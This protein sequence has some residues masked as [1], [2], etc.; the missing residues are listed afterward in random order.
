METTIE[1]NSLHEFINKISDFESD[2]YYY[3]GEPSVNYQS[4][5]ASAFRPYHSLFSSDKKITFDSQKLLDEYY[6]EIAHELS[7]IERD[8]FL[9][10]AQHHGLPTPLIDITTSPLTALYFACSSNFEENVSKVHVFNKNGFI[11][12]SNLENKGE[13]TL[14][15]FFFDNQFTYQVMKKISELSSDF[16]Q[17]LLSSCIF[18]LKSLLSKENTFTNQQYVGKE[19][20][21]THKAILQELFQKEYSND[22]ELNERFIQL[23][24]EKFG[25]D[26]KFNNR[27]KKFRTCLFYLTEN[28][29]NNEE[30]DPLFQVHNE[31]FF[32]DEIALIIIFLINTQ[33]S[34]MVDDYLSTLKTGE[35]VFPPVIMHPSVKFDRMK[36]QEGTFLYQ[37]P[38]YR[39]T[40][41]DYIGF[42]KIENDLEFII[43][44]KQ[45]IFTSLNKIGINRKTLFPDHDNVAEYLKTK[46]LIK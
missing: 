7:E 23:F 22:K 12:L 21:P 26:F 46:Y 29:E 34:N 24:K 3:R 14:N 44:D 5:L 20:A 16:K 27:K 45:S 38:H 42:T 25:M 6:T 39:G 43:K 33:S 17:K 10:Y 36:S 35:I 32:S 19:S 18:N 11:D 40:T 41:R 2:T 8:N 13:I 4:I 28:G 30:F 37:V 31:N 1:I 9:H 15:N